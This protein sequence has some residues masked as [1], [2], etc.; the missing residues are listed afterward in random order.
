MVK[1]FG[2]SSYKHEARVSAGTR[3][4][5][6]SRER[7]DPAEQYAWILEHDQA[8]QFSPARVEINFTSHR[9]I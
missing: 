9:N 2:I 8:S 3:F 5:P 4:G 7:I 6:E 1:N